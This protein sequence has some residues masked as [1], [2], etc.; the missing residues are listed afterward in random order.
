MRRKDRMMDKDFALSV[1]DRAEY[2][3]LATINEDGSPYC[4]PLSMAREND[5][6][7]FHSA[8]EGHK[9]ENIR[10]NPNV[11]LSFTGE[12]RVPPVTVDTFTTEFESAVVFGTA[13][14]VENP[15]ERKAALRL[16]SE[17][18]APE[19]MPFFEQAAE[20]ALNITCIVRID[21]KEITGKRKK[22]DT[23]GVEMKWG[24]IE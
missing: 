4:I 22:Y 17:K 10:R 9:L 6:I 20:K 1:I 3:T 7:Y 19:S 12:V 2:G 16:I 23:K 14:V 8:M 11:C 15:M 21:I 13:S 5:N 24:R 18:F